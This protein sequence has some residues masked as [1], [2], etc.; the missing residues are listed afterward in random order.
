MRLGR[1]N[2][3]PLI[4]DKQLDYKEKMIYYIPTQRV[5]VIYNK[6]STGRCNEWIM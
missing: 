3:T 5:G 6:K 1:I 4:F 2:I